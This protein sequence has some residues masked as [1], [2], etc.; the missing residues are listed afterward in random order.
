MLSF[1]K[2]VSEKEKT[3]SPPATTKIVDAKEKVVKKEV[4][5]EVKNEAPSITPTQKPTV[6]RKRNSE[7][8]DTAIKYCLCR[9]PER[10]G[11]I[12]CDFCEEW[13]HSS[14]L[15]LKKEDVKQLTKCK[16]KCPKCELTDSKQAKAQEKT[17]NDNIPENIPDNISTSS[18]ESSGRKLR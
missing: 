11:M 16:W 4:K 2:V 17:N 12:G 13:Y 7:K 8:E 15:N 3:S 6:K 5:K 10:P 9:E 14:C 18:E 1:K